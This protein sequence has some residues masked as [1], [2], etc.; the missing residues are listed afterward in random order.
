MSVVG[1]QMRGVDVLHIFFLASFCI[2]TSVDHIRCS[3][4]T[5]EYTL[6]RRTT[7][8]VVLEYTAQP[9]L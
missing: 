6:R 7:H 9:L 3:S 5:S 2:Q 1:L 4:C 8:S